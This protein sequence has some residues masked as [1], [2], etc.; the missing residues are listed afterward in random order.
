MK[1]IVATA[2]FCGGAALVT[3]AAVLP[4]FQPKTPDCAGLDLLGC[5]DQYTDS[6]RPW[7]ASDFEKW[8][9]ATWAADIDSMKSGCQGLGQDIIKAENGMVA[10][11]KHSSLAT[12]RSLTPVYF[13]WGKMKKGVREVG[14]YAQFDSVTAGGDTV[15]SHYLILVKDG[16][17]ELETWRTLVHEGGHHGGNRNESLAEQ[18]A[19]NDCIQRDKVEER[20]IRNKRGS[21]SGGGYSGGSGSGGSSTNPNKPNPAG[22]P[23]PCRWRPVWN[24]VHIVIGDYQEII[25]RPGWYYDCGG[26]NIIQ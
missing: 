18:I 17:S 20:K 23:N 8:S 10:A 19:V 4:Q 14:G 9:I 5:L 25:C 3:A 7:I 16:M 24:C 15:P 2:C 21:G 12:P 13:Y 6:H 22:D 1:R 11:F 26:G